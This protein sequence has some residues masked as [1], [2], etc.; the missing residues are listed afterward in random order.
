MIVAISALF[1]ALAWAGWFMAARASRT[2]KIQS[3][4]TRRDIAFAEWARGTFITVVP[5]RTPPGELFHRSLYD[6]QDA[7]VYDGILFTDPSSVIIHG[8][9]APLIPEAVGIPRTEEKGTGGPRRS[10]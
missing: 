3:D 2:V 9:D 1:C 7:N 10:A 4:R 8:G 5:A 6:L